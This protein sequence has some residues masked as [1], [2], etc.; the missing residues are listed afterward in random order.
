MKNPV[1]DFRAQLSLSLRDLANLANVTPLAIV[2]TEQGVFTNVPPNIVS[3]MLSTKL[4]VVGDYVLSDPDSIHEAYVAWQRYQRRAN[5]GKL[6][7]ELPPFKPMVSPLLHWRLTSSLPSQMG[8]CKAFCIHPS[9]VAQVETGK[10]RKLPTQLVDAL[11]QAGYDDNTLQNL[12][13]R[14]MKYTERKPLTAPGSL[15]NAS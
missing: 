4:V 6:T 11:A 9:P 13:H 5:F 10:Q 7:P 2:R 3:A 15:S 12:A 8:L 1:K 14:Q